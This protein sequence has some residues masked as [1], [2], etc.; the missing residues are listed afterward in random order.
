MKALAA[1][2]A[3]TL[4]L[5]AC[6][7]SGGD[8]IAPQASPSA[9][10]GRVAKE[11]GE[12][13]P[14]PAE[15]WPDTLIGAWRLAGVDGQPLDGDMGV[16]INI[17]RDRIEFDKCQQVVW[18]YSYDPPALETRRTPAITIDINPKPLPC[19]ATFPPQIAAMVEAIDA[20]I[21]A[22]RTPENGLRLSGQ[23]RSVLLFRQ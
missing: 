13:M 7:Q 21:Q 2:L 5:S 14:Q 12:R 15:P 4:L 22:E 1:S 3:V 9:A 11:I 23:G 17:G 20:A 6:G 19:A 8:E 16:A 18:A 10:E